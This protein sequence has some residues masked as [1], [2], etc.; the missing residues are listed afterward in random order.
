MHWAFS[1][2]EKLYLVMKEL[3]GKDLRFH[4]THFRLREDGILK[5]LQKELENVRLLNEEKE[6]G[7][8]SE[9]EEAPRRT[10]EPSSFTENQ[11]SNNVQPFLS[12]T[13]SDSISSLGFLMA[14]VCLALNYLH[15]KNIIHRDIKPENILCEEDGFIRITDLGIAKEL[16]PINNQDSSGTPGYMGSKHS[17]NSSISKTYSSPPPPTST[18]STLQTESLVSFIPHTV[19]HLF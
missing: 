8:V 5:H 2:N 14:Q 1:D 16:K 18:W 9:P 6:L 7:I 11:T 19:C 4:L 17:F 13:A 15:H 3:K 12:P 10:F